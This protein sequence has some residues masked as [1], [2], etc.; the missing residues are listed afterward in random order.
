DD[1]GVDPVVLVA[2]RRLAGEF[3]HEAARGELRHGRLRGAG[4]G[5]L[6]DASGAWR[7]GAAW[8]LVWAALFL[9]LWGATLVANA[10]RAQARSHGSPFACCDPG[11]TGRRVPLE[12]NVP[13]PAIRRGAKKKPRDR[14]RGFS[15]GAG[16][17]ARARPACFITSAA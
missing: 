8:S 13:P 1:L 9:G 14:S 15:S 11:W 7:A 2:H 12:A 16:R 17:V 4:V 10:F 6:A 3:Q 5:I